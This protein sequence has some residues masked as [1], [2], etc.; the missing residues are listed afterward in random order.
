MAAPKIYY[1]KELGHFSKVLVFVALSVAGL[2]FLPL[3]TV[4]PDEEKN[5]THLYIQ[6]SWPGKDPETVCTYLTS[7][8]EGMASLIDGISE[9]SSV[10]YRGVA[11]IRLRIDKKE[12]VQEI[13][14]R[15]RTRLRSMK[16]QLP[17]GV[18]FP[19]IYSGNDDN[20]RE[21]VIAE[22]VLYGNLSPDSLIVLTEQ[23]I[24]PALRQVEGVARAEMQ[25]SFQQYTEFRF[26]HR[27]MDRL[28]LNPQAILQPL[29]YPELLSGNGML[30]H[31]DSS[32]SFYFV[33]TRFPA[34]TSHNPFPH[35]YIVRS[36]DGKI[37]PLSQLF[38]VRSYIDDKES[39]F[40]FNGCNAVKISLI[41]QKKLNSLVTYYR[42]KKTE[43]N[44]VQ[45]LPATAFFRKTNDRIAPIRHDAINLVMQWLLS[46]VWLVFLLW[47]FLRDSRLARV[48]FISVPVTLLLSV[49][50]FYI[51]GLRLTLMSL[52]GITV[53]LAI[54]SDAFIMKASYLDPAHFF[55]GT[56]PLM[57]ASFTSAASATGL[58][59]LEGQQAA[60]FT[61]MSGVMVVMVLVALL[62]SVLF[63]PSVY[64][65]LP[66]ANKSD[67]VKTS[68]LKLNFL[69]N[70]LS[71]FNRLKTL[72]ILL[73]IL[74][75]GIPVY[76]LPQRLDSSENALY[77]IYNQ[78]FDNYR[79]S[80]KIR[81]T[82]EKYLGGIPFYYYRRCIK[83]S[84][85]RRQ[86][87]EKVLYFSFEAS[88][89]YGMQ[90]LK[91][92]IQGV[93]EQ[94]NPFLPDIY[95]ETQLT[96]STNGTITAGPATEKGKALLPLIYDKLLAYSLN[97]KGLQCWLT[98][99]DEGTVNKFGKLTGSYR[100]ILK[101]YSF[102][103]LR[104]L[105]H[106]AIELLSQNP[107]VENIE[108][109]SGQPGKDNFIGKPY[110]VLSADPWVSFPTGTTS[111]VLL[112]WAGFK[113]GD[114]QEV[115]NSWV[116]IRDTASPNSSVWEML[117]SQFH[118]LE[119]NFIPQ[120]FGVTEMLRQTPIY[121]LNQE[122]QLS[123]TYDLKMPPELALEKSREF[124]ATL[125]QQFPMGFSASEPDYSF[126]FGKEKF[127]PEFL[128]ILLLV[129]V[130]IYLI[131]TGFLN[132]FRAG[133]ASLL[134]MP[135]SVLGVLL[136]HAFFHSGPNAGT[137]AAIILTQG[138]VVNQLL[139]FQYTYAVYLPGYLSSEALIRAFSDKIRH[140]SVSVLS[141]SLGLIP[142][143]I[144]SS[145]GSVMSNFA[146][147]TLGGLLFSYL[148]FWVTF[149]F[150]AAFTSN[151]TNE[152][153]ER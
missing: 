78:I 52:A 18:L 72:I 24:L 76:L 61:S 110:P 36:A 3:L 54:I 33:S 92:F 98:Y 23:N 66:A 58:Y 95:F 120:T 73:L 80:E 19:A 43:K 5:Q 82:L 85:L 79:F 29:L 83:E 108:L 51:A 2:A 84:E 77:R 101:G 64:F 125:N 153:S 47:M 26:D 87:K 132:S 16:A 1:R 90:P 46:I 14:L 117:H 149:P 144:F 138:L 105:A 145:R 34:F 63:M 100:I 140:I 107:R 151:T 127:S 21:E 68:I 27:T 91:R 134:F 22:Y 147:G 53:S 111:D 12:N 41:G 94:L 20:P 152:P 118:T 99:G 30:R 116:S 141:V 35:E 128:I 6:A 40:R 49:V 109:Y 150:W 97:I 71:V 81:P 65:M 122:Y 45:Q 56:P 42:L 104:N 31:S 93:E 55:K 146:L 39:V 17:Q 142:V 75:I 74:L 32:S 59:F 7:R 37:L 130:F 62:V 25:T 4:V 67:K 50:L 113:T 11:I 106:D 48:V 44:L 60:V 123:I 28:G 70:Y 96:S 133:L 103:E 124:I 136:A 86:Q 135:L 10:S 112:N 129:Y 13:I 69:R 15:L 137:M 143:V 139:F 119:G 8:I 9:I 88:E 148:L 121:R 115:N 131:S 38:S 114:F 89:D 102:N 126:L 57:A